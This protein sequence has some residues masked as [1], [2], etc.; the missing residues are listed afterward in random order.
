MASNSTISI[1]FKLDGDG[2]GFRA[3]AQDA[4]GLRTVM[5]AT[6]EQSEMLKTSL[7]NW[8][9]ALQGLQSIDHAVN[10]I[11]DRL[12]SI[13]SES[14]QFGKAMKAANT[15]AGKDSEGYK[16]LKEEIADLSKQIPIARDQLA[17]GLYQVVSNG[18]PED[19]WISFLE[20]SAKSAVGGIAE[21][22]KVVG[23]TSTLIKNYGLEWDAAAEIQDKIQLTAKNGVTSFEQLAQALPRVTGNAATLGVTVDE[24]LGTFATLTGVSGNTAEVSTQ[25][26]AVFTALVKPSSEAAEMAARMGIQFDAAAIQAAGGFQNFLQ[27]LNGSVKAYSQA[28]GTLEQ[29]VYGKLFGSAEALR[30]LIPLQGE[31]ADKF[32]ANVNNMVN[33]S[34]TMDAAYADMSSSGD[35]VNQMLRNQWAT[36][37]DVVSGFTSATQPYIDFTAGLLSTASSATALVSTFRQLNIQQ[38]ILAARSNISTVAMA[39]L[40]LRGRSVAGVVR[41]FSSAMRGGAFSATAFKIALR[42]L[43]T[44]TGIGLAFVAVTSVIE[45]F[46]SASDKASESTN[47][48]I[49]AEERAKRE[50][51]QLE[52]MKQQELSTLTNTR[53]ALDLHINKLKEFNGSKEDEKRLVTEMNNTYG[54]SM[55]YFSTVADWYEALISNSEDY[56][57]QMVLEARTR[58]LVNQIAQKEQE[59]HNILYD[60]KG[61]KRKYST[62]RQLGKDQSSPAGPNS[63][64]P[65]GTRKREEIVGTSALDKATKAYKD[66]VEE[67]KALNKRL[68]DTVQEANK[69]NFKVKGSEK[70]PDTFMPKTPGAN[71]KSSGTSGSVNIV[72]EGP[73]YKKD[74]ANLLEINDNMR[75]LNNE[76][77]TA[78]LE[79]AAEIN[80]EL[81]QWEKLADAYR[82]AGK[83]A[84]EVAETGD[85]VYNANAST[86]KEITDNIQILNEQL[87]NAS[88]DDAAQINQEIAAWNKKAEAIRNAGMEAKATF[89]TFREGWDGVKGL[90][91]GIDTLTGAL[92]GNGNA[93]QTVTGIVDGFLQIYDGVKT[94]VSIIDMLSMATTA[95]TATKTAE[96]AAVGVSAGAQAAEVV[97][98]EAAAAA[99]IPVVAAN[100]A[101]TAS[102]LELASAAYFAAHAYIPFAGFGIASG[103]VT[104]AASIV[105]GIGATALTP[106]ANGGIVSGPTVGL[107]GEYAGASRNPEVVAPLDRL[108][109]LIGSDDDRTPRVVK[110]KIEGRTLVGIMEKELNFNKR[111]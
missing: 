93:W 54:E 96:A 78:S 26:A 18:V 63:Y 92:S 28:T 10:Q 47:R 66:N 62:R 22:N 104:A 76:L 71:N 82:N 98:A 17:N 88:I 97:S 14:E 20:T 27:Q 85:A 61:N 49:D 52:A 91:G 15:M 64:A 111:R 19:N 44:A 21:I 103:F 35:A 81:A 80:K 40:G 105:Q 65:T 41:V 39:A 6:L 102:Y 89:D 68:Q 83:E 75:V 24:L 90:S 9:A 74:A 13:T 30:A 110:F 56:C 46:C 50:A 59:Q 5:A 36:V 57:K 55:G 53:A 29:E 34:G 4:N 33:S 3:I 42:G 109:D 23:V 37:I 12:S 106:F 32:T 79:R 43:L 8:S 86:L 2:K 87:Q 69:I 101:A 77:L 11:S 100:K 25:L 60:E 7:I 95:H 99:Q 67:L 45:Y 51:E 1:T 108:R 38:A 84:T 72:Q 58:E 48:L 94:I 107:I 73:V 31:L 16:Q 70:R